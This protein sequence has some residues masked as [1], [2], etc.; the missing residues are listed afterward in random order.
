MAKKKQDYPADFLASTDPSST[1]PVR[2][3]NELRNAA[4]LLG[5][6]TGKVILLE[7]T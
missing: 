1:D 3:Y 4:T 2:E 5:W 7:E 6:R